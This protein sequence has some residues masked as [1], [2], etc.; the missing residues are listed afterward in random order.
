M[1]YS[2]ASLGLSKKLAILSSLT[3]LSLLLAG[4]LFFLFGV[5]QQRKIDQLVKTEIP[6]I[7]SLNDLSRD[8]LGAQA[9]LS[10]LIN[11]TNAGG[12]KPEQLSATADLAALKALGVEQGMPALTKAGIVDKE[13]GLAA[14]GF[15]ENVRDSL[16][17]LE[18]DTAFATINAEWAWEK[19]TAVNASLEKALAREKASTDDF[20]MTAEA[21]ARTGQLLQLAIILSSAIVNVL[22]SALLGRLIIRP[23]KT[24]CQAIRAIA[25]GDLAQEL[26]TKARDDELGQLMADIGT[27]RTRISGMVA[28]IHEESNRL[29]GIGEDLSADVESTAASVHQV[30]ANISSVKDKSLSQAEGVTETNAT[31][32]EIVSV[33]TS[34]DVCIEEQSACVEESSS[35]IEELVANVGSVSGVLKK[36]ASSV[37]ELITA[38]EEGKLALAEVS[39]IVQD[40]AKDSEG[41]IEA[42]T[43]IESIADQTNLLAMNAAIEA[44]HA[45]EAGKGFSVVADEIRKL[46]EDSS[47]QGRS[48][49]L[50]LGKLKQAIDKVAKSSLVSQERFEKVF[51]L[52]KIVAGQEGLIKDAM[53]EQSSGGAQIL[54]AI[55]QINRITNKVK[56]GSSQML[57]GSHGVL[58]EMDRLTDMTREI[59]D[60]MNEMADGTREITLVMN[61]VSEVSEMNRERIAVLKKE[62]SWFRLA[63]Q[64]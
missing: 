12:F 18:F 10:Q 42:G 40:I 45:G 53:I 21:E 54:E 43:V 9:A 39:S 59:T 36:N 57:A 23:L 13:T 16:A 51:E 14:A 26:V 35:S 11:R 27:L 48:I 1:K 29:I 50:V 64:G 2:F 60:S 32:R 19:Y 62:I 30:V 25:E 41:L 34:L 6:R 5:R 58:E 52:A 20:R 47:E 22:L 15:V 44:A 46:A 55:S 4:T 24:A 28:R 61:K 31:V 33:I 63:G 17:N 49:T 7:Q 38:S 56:E 37:Q 3:L 8:L